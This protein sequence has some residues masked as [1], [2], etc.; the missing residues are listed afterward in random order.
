[1]FVKQQRVTIQN[2]FNVQE[3]RKKHDYEERD[4]R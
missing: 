4:L 1:M 2:N 3:K